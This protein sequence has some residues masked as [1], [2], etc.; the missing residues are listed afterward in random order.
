MVFSSKESNARLGPGQLIHSIKRKEFLIYSIVTI[1]CAIIL[2]G[3]SRTRLAERFVLIDVGV[4]AL[5]GECWRSFLWK[6]ALGCPSLC[7][8]VS[9]FIIFL[10]ALSL[11][12]SLSSGGFTVL[13]TKGL[14]SLL[15]ARNPLDMIKYPITYVLLA[16]LIATAIAQ[17]TYLNRALYRF[18]SREVIPT[19]FVFFT[20]SAIVGSAVLYRDFENVEPHRFINFIF[21]CLTTFGGVFILTRSRGD[22]DEIQEERYQ[23][24][25]STNPSLVS[26]PRKKRSKKNQTSS[27]SSNYLQ[28]PGQEITSN[29]QE[30]DLD[31]DRAV[32]VDILTPT[33]PS[34]EAE[35]EDMISPLVST[36][37]RPSNQSK[38]PGITSS[39]T[40]GSVPLSNPRRTVKVDPEL[41]GSLPNSSHLSEGGQSF[42][43]N[44]RLSF[45][46]PRSS[47]RATPGL[48]F[49]A[50]HYLLLASSSSSNSQGLLVPTNGINT[51]VRPRNTDHV[52]TRSQSTPGNRR[53]NQEGGR[54]E[55]EE[56]SEG[57]AVTSS[58]LNTQETDR[59]AEADE[60]GDL[61]MEFEEDEAPKRRSTIEN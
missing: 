51:P 22:G 44:H 31:L 42:V 54:R 24:Q 5:F 56:S 58:N 32:T 21:G 49:S 34:S 41:S 33:T 47:P 14:S 29:L 43:R 48:G 50:G 36:S 57:N 52:R 53:R 55:R 37:L 10:F 19:Q 18:D 7:V 17:I 59:T 28:V 45:P 3:L 60:I 15:S 40:T 46:G 23:E 20:I 38:H 9:L 27:T 12:P 4:C 16:I 25:D 39:I 30:L 1:S 13:S 35:R 61:Q 11:S 2:M 8:C 6:A 26:T